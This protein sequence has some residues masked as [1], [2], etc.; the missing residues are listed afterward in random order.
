M[1]GP[2]SSWFAR[3]CAQVEE[4]NSTIFS[5]DVQGVRLWREGETGDDAGGVENM[6]ERAVVDV[7]DMDETV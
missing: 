6:G 7:I 4:T 1:G 5:G 3:F 2:C